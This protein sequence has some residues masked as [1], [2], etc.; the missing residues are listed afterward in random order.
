[1]KKFIYF[2]GVLALMAGFVSCE[3]EEGEDDGNSKKAKK[4]TK[5][6]D[7][8]SYYSF[9]Y[10]ESGRCSSYYDSAEDETAK[11][12]YY[13]GKIVEK[14]C[15]PDGDVRVTTTLS[16]NSDGYLKSMKVEN[17]G[18]EITVFSYDNQG[19]LVSET[20]SDE[21]GYTRMSKY[22]WENGNITKAETH[23]QEDGWS[24]DM[25]ILFEYTNS[26]NLTP[27]ENKVGFT[28]MQFNNVY[29]APYTI[30]T[31]YAMIGASLKNLPVGLKYKDL[32]EELTS[33]ITWT[34]DAEGYPTKM[35]SKEGYNENSV[36]FVWE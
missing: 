32:S 29:N 2:L 1:M 8:S 5:V 3:K 11:Y 7:G 14:V 18:A 31:P 36:E 10:D 30:S 33:T 21:D 23:E 34:M 19:Q 17:G 26:E 20:V 27:I 25:T 12:T 16:L 35:L 6:V 28:I 15:L 4:L 22:T 9:A 24:Y 13:D